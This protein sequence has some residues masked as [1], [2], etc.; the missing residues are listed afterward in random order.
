MKNV[1]NF[2]I[3]CVH[4]TK[5]DRQ[6]LCAHHTTEYN[7]VTGIPKYIPCETARS[8]NSLCGTNGKDFVSRDT[9]LAGLTAN[10]MLGPVS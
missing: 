8:D 6:Y 5:T 1:P 7:L 9:S 10:A 3:N 2:C 4:L